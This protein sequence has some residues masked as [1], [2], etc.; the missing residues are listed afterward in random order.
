MRREELV[1]IKEDLI[2]L[3]EATLDNETD[4][5]RLIKTVDVYMDI[6]IKPKQKTLSKTR[7][8]HGI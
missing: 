1:K 4:K 2:K 7:K 5:D 3:I 6:H 8:K